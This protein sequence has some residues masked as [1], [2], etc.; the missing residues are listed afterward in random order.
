MAGSFSDF[1]KA[2]PAFPRPRGGAPPPN[3]RPQESSSGIFGTGLSADQV[4]G[5]G[6]FADDFFRPL[7]GRK[8]EAAPPPKPDLPNMSGAVVG[9]TLG[10]VKPQASFS[11]NVRA[12]APRSIGRKAPTDPLAGVDVRMGRERDMTG[13]NPQTMTPQGVAAPLPGITMDDILHEADKR[14]SIGSWGALQHGGAKRKAAA[15]AEYGALLDAAAKAGGVVLGSQAKVSGDI[16]GAQAGMDQQRTQTGGFDR[17]TKVDK[18]LGI[19]ANEMDA[20]QLGETIRHNRASESLG[21]NALS[22]EQRLALKEAGGS[23]GKDYDAEILKSI[24][25]ANAADPQALSS[26]VTNYQN[27]KS[28]KVFVPG[29]TTGHLWWKNKTED[30]WADP[31]EVVK[32]RK[33]ANG[34]MEGL[35]RDGRIVPIQARALGGPVQAGN[36]YLVGEDGPEVKVNIDEGKDSTLQN[37][38]GSI[39]RGQNTPAYEVVGKNGPEIIQPQTS[40]VVLPNPATARKPFTTAIDNMATARTANPFGPRLLKNARRESRRGRSE[41][42]SHRR[43]DS[44]HSHRA[45]LHGGDT[46]QK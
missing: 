31:N 20:R 5:G 40:G 30:Q 2:N 10:A 14:L 24:I 25:A 16:L 39:D 45:D 6:L 38:T 11:S 21:N 17:R 7:G 41:E 27:V 23:P 32:R 46:A 43:S 22:F 28:G 36:P 8:A 19:L 37:F 12:K 18:E 4:A 33:G 34:Q 15:A 44:A 35:T 1:A 9:A 3:W 26:A 29:K 13:L 42:T